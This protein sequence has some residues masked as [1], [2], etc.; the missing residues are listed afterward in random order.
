MT[1][2]IEPLVDACSECARLRREVRSLNGRVTELIAEKEALQVDRASMR[3]IRD[4]SHLTALN[5]RTSGED[6]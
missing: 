4:T 2:K 5:A 3:A 1:S 6:Q